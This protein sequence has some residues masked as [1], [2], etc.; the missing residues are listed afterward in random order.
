MPNGN[1]ALLFLSRCLH[2]VQLSHFRNR[3]MYALNRL[4]CKWVGR[5]FLRHETRPSINLVP[6]GWRDL[7][8]T[9]NI[10]N[11]LWPWYGHSNWQERTGS[12]DTLLYLMLQ[13]ASHRTLHLFFRFWS[14]VIPRLASWV[15]ILGSTLQNIRST[16][17]N[18]DF[19]P[20]SYRHCHLCIIHEH[21]FNI[22]VYITLLRKFPFRSDSARTSHWPMPQSW[23]ARA[24]NSLNSHTALDT[25]TQSQDNIYQKPLVQ[26]T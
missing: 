7:L 25:I 22:L 5:L 4:Y 19:T 1:D 24:I 6:I 14:E 20:A 16:W 18:S 13:N 12:G 9:E 15:N 23:S 8:N 21:K 10:N 11:G 3:P 17:Q 2:R 26:L